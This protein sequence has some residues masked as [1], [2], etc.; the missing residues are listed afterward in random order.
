MSRQ[1][2]SFPKNGEPV[3]GVCSGE[4]VGKSDRMV[5]AGPPGSPFRWQCLTWK[6]L[7]S[8]RGRMEKRAGWEIL[9]WVSQG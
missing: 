3:E 9:I 6:V 5:V 8:I 7:R 2:V 1:T 4:E